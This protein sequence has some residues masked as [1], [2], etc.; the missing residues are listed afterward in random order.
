MSKRIQSHLAI[1]KINLFHQGLIRTLVVF[2]L[3][4]VQRSWDWLIHSLKPNLQ[5]TKSKTVKGKNLVKEK[6]TSQATKI[7]MKEDSLVARVTR[8]A[9]EN[10]KPNKI[11]V[12]FL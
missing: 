8:A 3:N 5:P 10:Y 1:T 6:Q 11:L 12:I 4:E 2:S 9:R 7:L